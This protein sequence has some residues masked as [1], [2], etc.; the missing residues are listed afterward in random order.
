MGK[1]DQMRRAIEKL[2]EVDSDTGRITRY[3]MAD[4][5][6]GKMEPTGETI[7]VPPIWCRVSYQ[8]GGVWPSKADEAGLTID[9]TPYILAEHDADLR[10]DDILLWRGKRY[11]VGPVSRAS[12]DGGADCTQAPL[13]EVKA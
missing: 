5:G 13:T 1:L 12:I 8:A 7:S 9:T 2:I 4:N 10:M 11:K 6:R 3:A